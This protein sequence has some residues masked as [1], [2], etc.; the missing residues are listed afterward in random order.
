MNKAIAGFVSLCLFCTLLLN[1]SIASAGSVVIGQIN[2]LDLTMFGVTGITFDQGRNP[3]VIDGLGTA[4]W[5]LD[6]NDASVISTRLLAQQALT[7]SL[8]FDLATSQYFTSNRRSGDTDTLST[9]DPTT[10]TVREIG[11]IGTNFDFLNLAIDPV[12]HDLWLV[13]DCVN[14]GCTMA[15]GGSLWRVDKLTGA[16]TPVDIF[17]T[18]LG[19]LTALAISPQE[20]FFVASS[21]SI[22]EIDP[23]T[24]Q[25]TFITDTGLPSSSFFN[26]FNSL[27]FDPSTDNLYGIEERRG[28]EPR[29]WYLDEVTGLPTLVPEPG[30]VTLLLTGLGL[31]LTVILR[32]NYLCR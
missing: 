8:A 27:A 10:G 17:G 32:P 23:S 6:I 19:Q 28:V 4:L 14:I 31:L 15:G 12:T 26:F 9:V 13:N 16:A 11:V 25:S 2:P 5:R 20:Q 21:S 30:T 3:L 7:R 1:P 18:S 29:A 24:G 22:Y